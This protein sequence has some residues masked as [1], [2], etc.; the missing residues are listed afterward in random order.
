MTSA[1]RGNAVPDRHVA[2]LESRHTEVSPGLRSWSN[3]THRLAFEHASPKFSFQR[4]QQAGLEA[5]LVVC[6]G[7]EPGFL[8]DY[9][10]G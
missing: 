6:L 10:G 3:G 9:G 8:G 1:H 7:Q 2:R 4:P 5:T